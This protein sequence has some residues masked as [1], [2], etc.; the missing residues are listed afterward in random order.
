MNSYIIGIDLGT[1]NSALAYCKVDSALQT[2]KVDQVQRQGEIFATKTLA[3]AMYLPHEK[4]LR[5]EEIRLPWESSGNTQHI[6][7]NWAL[8]RGTLSPDRL[9]VSAKS[10]LIN[11]ST[12]PREEILPWGAEHSQ[13]VSALQALTA[14]LEHLKNAFLHTVRKEDPNLSLEHCKCVITIP[15]SFDEHARQLVVEAA[16]KASL[17]NL[18]LLEEPQAAFYSYISKNLKSWQKEVQAGDLVLVCDVGGGTSDFSLI[19]IH[20]Q[21]GQLALERIAVGEHL[22]LGGDNMDMALAYKV[23]SDFSSQGTEL[24]HWQFL[25]LVQEVRRAKES[26]LSQSDLKEVP[27]SITKRGTKLIANTISTNLTRE[28]VESLI[29]DGFFPMN[30]L[31]DQLEEKSLGIQEWGLPFENDPAITKH[32]SAFLKRAYQTVKASPHLSSFVKISEEQKALRPNLILFNGGV[33]EASALRERIVSVLQSWNAGASVRVLQNLELDLAVAEGA[34]YF[35]RVKESGKGVRIKAGTSASYYIGVKAAQLAVPGVKNTMRGLCIVPQGTEEGTQMAP[36]KN[37]F[38]LMTGESVP[39]RFFHSKKRGSDQVGT[40]VSDAEMNLEESRS[41]TVSLPS[42]GSE[43]QMVPVT[44][45]ASVSDVGTLHLFMKHTK[46]DQ[47]WQL[48]FDLR[49]S[50]GG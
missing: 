30:S 44:L 33:F 34:A 43:K 28:S 24:D 39:F 19:A 2:L 16:N 36:N 11:R 10:W 49:K 12:D 13:K 21:E 6:V 27:I 26:L 46:S 4:E 41:L 1:S 40:L 48:E 14:Y 37:Q 29:I 35:A 22:L 7:G 20:D 31:E 23:Q 38:G 25:S 15:A 3:S 8:T 45:E 50:E 9:I 17:Q 18:S 32:L 42:V 47:K 5:E